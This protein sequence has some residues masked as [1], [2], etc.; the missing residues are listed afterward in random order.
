MR[1]LL[2][3]EDEDHLA[4]GLK[5]NFEAEGYDV[6]VATNGIDAIE[7]MRTADPP[8]E[9]V[10]LDLMLPDMSGYEICE[11]IRAD[12]YEVPIL[13]LS[14]RTLAEDKTRAFDLGIDQYVIH[15]PSEAASLE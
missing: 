3:V 10:V 13:V 4:L 14:A 5:F 12:N 8:M 2:I 11:A 15:I 7:I 6:T 9:L 1:R